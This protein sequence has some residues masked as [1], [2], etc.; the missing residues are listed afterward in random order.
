MKS[1]LTKRLEQFI[2]DRQKAVTEL[3]S[4]RRFLV[5]NTA[6]AEQRDLL[7]FFQQHKQLIALLGCLHEIRLINRVGWE[8]DLFG[9]YQVDFVAGDSR[10]HSYTFVE[11]QD[12]SQT[13][14]FQTSIRANGIWAHSFEEAFGQVI[15]WS[16]K[17]ADNEKSYEFEN[18]FESERINARFVIVVGRSCFLDPADYK[19]FDW[20]R[21]KI[22][23]DGNQL[24]CLTYDELLQSYDALITFLPSIA[25]SDR[26]S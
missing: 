24:K 11:F 1:H 2:P 26:S 20:R 6:L 17:L 8:F 9:D 5:P 22:N 25:Q 13:S 16:Y 15:D 18:R 14:I 19:R 3:E 10:Q 23:L 12:A 21:R 4:F 7:P